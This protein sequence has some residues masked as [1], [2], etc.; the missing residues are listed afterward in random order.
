MPTNGNNRLAEVAHYIIARTPPEMLGATKLNKVLW[1]VDCL[2]YR[3]WG[4]SLTGL[5]HYVRLQNGPVPSGLTDAI[6]TLKSDGKVMEDPQITPVGVRREFVSLQEP[7]FENFS[8]A[9]IDLIRAV[10]DTIRP[11]SAR[12]V[13]DLSHDALWHELADGA[14][15]TVAAGS[16]MPEP[17][18]DA[19]YQ[20]A[21][22]EAERLDLH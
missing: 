16:V 21:L 6:H 19:A 8:A 7:D 14:S 1:F 4:R 17:M 11:M 20:W 15:I 12:R 22:A 2:A 9:E 3:K 5:T 18:S 10:I 13:S